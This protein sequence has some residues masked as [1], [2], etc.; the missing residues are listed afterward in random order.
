MLEFDI[1]EAAGGQSEIYIRFRWS[2]T[3]GYSWEIDDIKLYDTPENDT[4]IDN[5]LSY[6]DY[7]R[8]GYYEYGAWAQSQIPADLAAAAKIYN[9]GYSEQTNVYLEVTADGTT[10][11]SDGITLAYATADT[12]AVPYSPSGLGMVEVDYT[13]IADE[14]DE[15]PEN[16]IAMQSF[17]VTDLS[18]GRDDGIPTA[19]A[20]AEGTDDYI[21][22]SLF[23]VVEDVVIYSIDVAIMDGAEIG[24]P[25]VAHL[26]NAF[27]DSFLSEQ[28]GGIV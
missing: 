9:V 11:S 12:L 22:M 13:L 16:N 6:T 28:Y 24:T 17:E 27:D 3:W 20:P 18:W 2:G 15:N 8:T 26:F 14:V 7:E 5:Y 19:A 4:R 1:T 21:A 10:A 23:D 25:I